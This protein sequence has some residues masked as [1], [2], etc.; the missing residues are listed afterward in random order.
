MF[1]HVLNHSAGWNYLFIRVKIII[2]RSENF[3]S[4]VQTRLL[5]YLILEFSCTALPSQNL[6]L[7][8]QIERDKQVVCSMAL[9]HE[10]HLQECFFFLFFMQQMP[11]HGRRENENAWAWEQGE[12]KKTQKYRK[13]ASRETRTWIEEKRARNNKSLSYTNTVAYHLPK[14]EYELPC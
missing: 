8:S 4:S 10:E 14:A 9:E 11:E 13:T 5:Y 6:S 2:Q 7:L 12:W 1:H 3:L